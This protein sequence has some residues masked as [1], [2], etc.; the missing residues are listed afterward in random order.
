MP[1][2]IIFTKPLHDDD[3]DDVGHLKNSWWPLGVL[4]KNSITTERKKTSRKNE[5]QYGGGW[6]WQDDWCRLMA[7]Y[8]LREGGREQTL[9]HNTKFHHMYASSGYKLIKQALALG[10]RTYREA[11]TLL[12]MITASVTIFCLFVSWV[13]C[14]VL[15]Y[16]D[17]VVVIQS[18]V[19][20]K[21]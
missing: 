21:K 6:Q 8:W 15:I 20:T 4:Q 2:Y 17:D 16:N 9:S 19:K 11:S 10:L 12:H 13:V 18:W 3:D 1:V 14:L 7:D 5:L